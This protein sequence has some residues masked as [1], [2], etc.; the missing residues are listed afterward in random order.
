MN[1]RIFL[2]TSLTAMNVP[3]ALS[4]GLLQPTRVLADW[5]RDMFFATALDDALGEI[6]GGNSLT[7]RDAIEIHAREILKIRE[8]LNQILVRHTQQPIE[9]IREDTERDYFMA[10]VEA[11]EYGLV[12]EVIENLKGGDTA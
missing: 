12:D 8:T 9:K 3:L 5:P 2:G 6:S 11:K 1:R 4:L 10:G 7:P